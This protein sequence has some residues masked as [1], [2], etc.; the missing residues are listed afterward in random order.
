M[1]GWRGERYML[2]IAEIGQALG[3]SRRT[4]ERH[5]RGGLIPTVR[6]GRRRLVP[7]AWVAELEAEA[8][9]R[10]SR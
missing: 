7:V 5:I 10:A 3:I 4:T 8:L 2:S 6:V 9:A 1:D